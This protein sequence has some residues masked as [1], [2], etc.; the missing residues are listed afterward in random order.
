MI[1][2]W[3]V[4]FAEQIIYTRA[5]YIRKLDKDLR[6]NVVFTCFIFRIACLGHAQ[7]A[8]LEAASEYHQGDDR[9]TV[10]LSSF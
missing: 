5:V 4:R 9:G 8:G 2:L 1:A 6:R 10:L 7:H 3:I